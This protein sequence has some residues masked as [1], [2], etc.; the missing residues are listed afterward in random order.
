MLFDIHSMLLYGMNLKY[1]V[2]YQILKL[3]L[4]KCV[5]ELTVIE[6]NVEG[7]NVL[8]FWMSLMVSPRK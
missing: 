4:I 7:N 8:G 1:I 5:I 3:T 2:G 6:L